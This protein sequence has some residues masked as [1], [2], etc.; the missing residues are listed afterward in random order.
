MV[1]LCALASGSNGNCYYIGTGN[2]AVLIDA[3]IPA[4]RILERLKRCQLNPNTIRAIFITHEHGDHVSGARV[5]SRRLNI[6]VYLTRNTFQSLY[7]SHRPHSICF[8]SPGNA[9]QI[10][11]IVLYPFLKSHDAAEPC[12][13]RVEAEGIQTGVITDLGM[14]DE[15]VISQLKPCHVLFLE[16]NYD[17]SMLWSGSYSLPLKQRIASDKGHLSNDQ[18]FAL[19]N[20]HAGKGLREIFLSH[21]SGENNTPQKVMECFKPLEKKYSIRLT[22]R[23]DAGEVVVLEGFG[24]SG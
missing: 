17:E 2:E 9:I 11:G 5:L 4:R 22:S 20:T 7:G 14:A 6:P 15:D 18:A 10:G 23:H 1:V 24:S 19:L 16:S 12:S 13:F 8:F 21:L 3:G